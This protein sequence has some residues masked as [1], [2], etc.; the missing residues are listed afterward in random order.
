M[1]VI[2]AGAF[3]YRSSAHTSFPTIPLLASPFPSPAALFPVRPFD[4]RVRSDRKIDTLSPSVP[5]VR[6][7]K[8]QQ[9]GKASQCNGATPRSISLADAPLIV[10]H[11]RA[12]ALSNA[13]PTWFRTLHITTRTIRSR[14]TAGARWHAI[15]PEPQGHQGCHVVM[16]GRGCVPV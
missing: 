9:Q 3:S 2:W 11:F 7:R 12:W 1:Q 8:V 5:S 14:S 10:S 6:I 16:H 4:T 15:T 13:R